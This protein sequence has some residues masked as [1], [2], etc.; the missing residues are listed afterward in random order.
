LYLAA[1]NYQGEGRRKFS[2]G[3]GCRECLDTGFRGRMGIYE[4]MEVDQNLRELI[5]KDASLDA[6]RTWF[7]ESDGQTLL[8]S[9]IELAEKEVTSLEEVS[10]IALFD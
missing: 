3:Q 2:R 1:I 7:D 5:A 8:E 10:R 9:G 4:V 6:V